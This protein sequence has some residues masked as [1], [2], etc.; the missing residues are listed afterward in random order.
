M[1]PSKMKVRKPKEVFSKATPQAVTPKVEHPNDGNKLF[2][3]DDD[4]GTSTIP[5]LSTEPKEV[6]EPSL[7]GVWDHAIDTIFKLSTFYPDG[8]SWHQWVHYQTMDTME[9]FL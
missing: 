9:Q 2:D 5:D 4:H 1:S 6:K 8:K 3:E 7:I